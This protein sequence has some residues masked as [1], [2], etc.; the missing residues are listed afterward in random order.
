VEATVKHRIVGSLILLSVAVII[1][2]FWL[3]GAG[4]EEYQATKPFTQQSTKQQPAMPEA[5]EFI[6]IESL[7]GVNGMDS[8]DPSDK[9]VIEISPILVVNQP[10]ATAPVKNKVQLEPSDSLLNQQGLPNGWVVQLGNFGNRSNAIRLKDKAIKAGFAA[11][12]VPNGTLFKVLVG[13]E[14]NRLK[15][16]ALQKKLQGQFKMTGMVTLYE[17]EKP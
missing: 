5:G 14:L 13:P 2:P 8:V 10:V 1:L 4:L 17:V 16:E 12:M 3:D 9:Q 15:A 7:G 11:Y 6:V